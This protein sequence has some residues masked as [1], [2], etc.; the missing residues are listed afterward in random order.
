MKI[1]EIL[2]EIKDGIFS[3]FSIAIKYL[4]NFLPGVVITLE[5]S[6]L[7]ILLG[8]VF[9]IIGKYFKND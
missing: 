7:S 2:L 1:L 9:G 3:F 5:L 8:I 6:I 4:P